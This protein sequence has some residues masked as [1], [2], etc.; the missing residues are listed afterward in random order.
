MSIGTTARARQA[1]N[2]GTEESLA[3]FSFHSF[4]DSP[5]RIRFG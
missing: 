5:P 3:R 2:Q 4:G 1:L